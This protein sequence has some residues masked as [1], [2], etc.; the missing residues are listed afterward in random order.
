MIDPH[1]YT[2]EENVGV[3]SVVID[4]EQGVFGEVS[5]VYSISTV[6]ASSADYRLEPDV[7]ELTFAAGQSQRTLNIGIVNDNG[8]EIEEEFCVGLTLPRFGAVLGNIT[9]S[10]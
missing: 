3:V 1:S 7:G 4:R 6:S 5:V 8:P 9:T 2:V 10:E